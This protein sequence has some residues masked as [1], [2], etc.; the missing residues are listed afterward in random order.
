MSTRRIGRFAFVVLFLAAPTSWAQSWYAGIGAGSSELDLSSIE[1]ELK[2][3]IDFDETTMIPGVVSE[4]SLD[5]SDSALK[6]ILGRQFN[7]NFAIEFGYADLG[8]GS[9]RVAVIAEEDIPS[10]GV[11]AGE[12][13][14]LTEDDSIDGFYFSAVGGIP[15][16]ELISIRGRLGAYA[17]SL[18]Y[19]YAQ[20]DTT[21]LVGSYTESDSESD[22]VVLYGVSL[23]FNFDSGFGVSLFY[24][25][26]D[27]GDIAN[28]TGVAATFAFGGD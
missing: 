14:V 8:E 21:G 10:L 18:D 9:T 17:Y 24:D 19:D 2:S 20:T 15:L 16:S 4:V 27:G 3:I 13:I 22:V 26:Y 1:S 28:T 6:L 12:N 7:E 5:D 23:D 25:S 11:L